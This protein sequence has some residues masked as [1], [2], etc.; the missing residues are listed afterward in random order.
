MTES[1]PTYDSFQDIIVDGT[2]IYIGGT[3]SSPTK[4]FFEAL[5]KVGTPPQLYEFGNQTVQ[6]ECRAFTM[7]GGCF[8]LAGNT[9]LTGAT[10]NTDI[11]LVKLAPDYS[12]AWN[13]TWH[14]YDRDYAYGVAVNGTNVYVAGNIDSA[15]KSFQACVIRFDTSGNLHENIS[16]GGDGSDWAGAMAIQGSYIYTLG[17][18]S[19]IPGLDWEP[20]IT[21]LTLNGPPAGTTLPPDDGALAT[22]VT[23]I[24][25]AAIGGCIV[26]LY[27]LDKKG[28]IN[29][30]IVFGKMRGIFSKRK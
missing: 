30:K 24:I 7:A 14:G 27:V 6:A 25:I 13:R 26:L 18:H 5:D 8:Y 15:T 4:L 3:H 17:G 2:H 21:R 28:V 23:V 10:Q 9:N 12:E 16:W 1:N 11:L 20:F 19:G 29:L 22:T